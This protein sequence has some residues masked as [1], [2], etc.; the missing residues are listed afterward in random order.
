MQSVVLLATVPIVPVLVELNHKVGYIVG[1]TLAVLAI[2]AFFGTLLFL[3]LEKAR[4]LRA[5]RGEKPKA[6]LGLFTGAFWRDIFSPAARKRRAQE[7]AARRAE[8][9]AAKEAERAAKE[10][11][12]RAKEAELAAMKKPALPAAAIADEESPATPAT[13][14][15]ARLPKLTLPAAGRRPSEGQPPHDTARTPTPP[16]RT[17]RS[18]GVLYVDNI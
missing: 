10:S 2:V 5:S 6:S 11:E 7:R 8:A 3:H 14:R 18:P 16:L 12:R 17:P 15:R 4:D 1:P 9:R 13:A